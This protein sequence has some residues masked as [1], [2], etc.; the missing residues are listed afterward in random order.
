[1]KLERPFYVDLDTTKTIKKLAKEYAHARY[2]I[3]GV[4]DESKALQSGKDAVESAVNIVK[5]TKEIGNRA[6]SAIDILDKFKGE[7]IKFQKHL[8]SWSK[9]Q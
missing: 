2:S 8:K 3:W 4:E 5:E 9:L 1:M 7:L 6:D